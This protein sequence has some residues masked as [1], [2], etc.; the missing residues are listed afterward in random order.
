[1]NGLEKYL[2]KKYC[3]KYGLDSQEVD[4]TLTYWENIQ[5]LRS[6][7]KMLCSS[8]DTSE[9]IA[10][11]EGLQEEYILNHPIEFF[12]S[13]RTPRQPDSTLAEFSLSHEFSLKALLLEYKTKKRKQLTIEEQ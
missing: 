4:S 13:Y 8:L 9:M 2:L 10:Q 5:H 12:M 3:R 6:L 7:V 11:M 1:L